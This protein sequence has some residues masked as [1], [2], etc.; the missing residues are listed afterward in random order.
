M[1]QLPLLLALLLQSAEVKPH[2]DQWPQWRGPLGTGVAPHAD[3]P[4][5]W[6][7]T[8][9]LRWK[10]ALPGRGHSSPVVFGER[11]FVTTA[12]PFGEPVAPRPALDPG[13]HDNAPLT[14]AWRF[15]V[16]AY[17]RA[18]GS[19][20]WRRAVK[21]EF[22]H[23][24]AH[25]SAG[26]ASPSPVTNGERLF[27]S[28][29]SRGIFCL[30]MEGAVL[31]E[32]DL[33]DMSVKHDHGEGSSPALYGDSLLLNWDHEGDSFV[34][35]LDEATG[36]ERWRAERDEVTSWSSPLVVS[37]GDQQQLVV[38]GSQRVR[39]YDLETGA[40]IWECAGL[41]RNVVA[42]PVAAD[43]RVI[44]GSSYEKQAML[45]IQWTEAKGDITTDDPALLWVRRKSTPYVPSPLLYGDAVYFLHHY[46]NTLSRVDAA[47]G[48]EPQRPFRLSGI[49]NVYASLVGAANRIYIS[50]LS[51]ATLVLSH[52]RK[53]RVLG[54]NQLDDSFSATP[55]AVGDALFLRGDH[56]LY[57]LARD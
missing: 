37:A 10:T 24:A 23:Q 12:V 20:L 51:G 32:K 21:E 33:G 7:E 35:A 26:F 52:G 9:N 41:S 54:L 4:V 47:T 57:C 43:G 55:A 3:P 6:S 36:E 19:L 16:L 13:S 45:G 50:D 56:W 18:D 39:A 11:V 28:F 29:G 40:V 25:E 22:P 8:E 38:A 42:T 34:L 46:Q 27:A 31:W 5:R 2:L 15:E 17:D 49:G 14:Q 1:I 53:P 30:D 44:V 48:D